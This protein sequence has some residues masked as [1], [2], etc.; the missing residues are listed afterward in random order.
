MA[1]LEFELRKA[2]DT[3]Q[4]LRGALTKNAADLCSPDT[5]VDAVDAGLTEDEPIR[6]YEARA[7]NFLVNEY[8]L[9]QSYRMTS[10]TFAEENENQDFEDWDD[11]GLNMPKPPDLIHLYRDFG[12]RNEVNADTSDAACMTD[13]DAE[14]VGEQEAMVPAVT[15]LSVGVSP[16]KRHI[17]F[18]NQN[19][20]K[21][22]M[23]FFFRHMYR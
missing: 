5:P 10:V 17:S 16:K 14:A 19:F 11:V 6:Q 22:D 21:G 15:N 1:V 4:S 23:T 12:Q 9:M 7:L 13:M 8:L 2:Q 20:F 3:I 18:E